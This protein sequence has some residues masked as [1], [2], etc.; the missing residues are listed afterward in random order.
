MVIN[1]FQESEKRTKWNGYK[2]APLHYKYLNVIL[3]KIIDSR[4]NLIDFNCE[5]D[6]FSSR[7]RM[8]EAEHRRECLAAMERIFGNDISKGDFIA[9]NFFALV[10]TN[11]NQEFDYPIP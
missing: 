1:N 8:I 7:K 5:Q 9:I 2:R 6:D 11:S 3:Y 10:F 4:A